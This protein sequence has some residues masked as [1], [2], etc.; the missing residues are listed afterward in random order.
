[1]SEAIR[2]EIGNFQ[3]IHRADLILDRYTCITGKSNRGK[4]AI[5][6]A[7]NVLINNETGDWFM[8]NDTDEPAFITLHIKGHR[9]HWERDQKGNVHYDI[10]G[11]RYTGLKG[12]VP[13]TNSFLLVFGSFVI[14]T[15]RTSKF[16][17]LERNLT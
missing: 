7:L 6:R 4:S 10:D 14:L 17:W 15:T 12:K 3:N 2:L 5:V 9:I 8:R 13:E 1:M 16:L 11:D